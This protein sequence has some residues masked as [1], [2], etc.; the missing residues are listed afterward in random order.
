MDVR[1]KRIGTI[2]AGIIGDRLGRVPAASG[3]EVEIS[4]PP[5]PVELDPKASGGT[6]NRRAL[7]VAGGERDTKARVTLLL[8]QFGFDTFDAG[9][10]RE[11][12]RN[13]RD[14]PGYGSRRT[15]EEL[16]CDLAEARRPRVTR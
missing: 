9:A 11:G 4:K 13:Q 12:W 16:R 15:A 8:D 10:L 2:G 6:T 3:Y 1:N 7:L 14:T 5:E